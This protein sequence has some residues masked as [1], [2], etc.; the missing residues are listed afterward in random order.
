MKGITDI[1]HKKFDN[2]KEAV[3]KVSMCGRVDGGKQ[4]EKDKPQGN[5]AKNKGGLSNTVSYGCS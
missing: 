2:G 3:E 1:A 5:E 4:N